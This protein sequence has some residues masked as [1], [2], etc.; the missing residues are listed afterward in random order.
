MEIGPVNSVTQTVGRSDIAVEQSPV[1]SPEQIAKDRELIKAVR[2]IDG[3]QLFGPNSELTFVYDRQSQRALARVVDKKTRQVV[4][5]IPPEYV[6]KM[7][8]KNGE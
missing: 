6:I 3:S 1:R 7:A 4:M 5:Q 2:A 8:E